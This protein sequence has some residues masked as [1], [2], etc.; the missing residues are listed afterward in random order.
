MTSIF[1]IGDPPPGWPEIPPRRL[2]PPLVIDA[3]PDIRAWAHAEAERIYAEVMVREAVPPAP[4]VLAE[5]RAQAQIW[6]RAQLVKI[7]STRGMVPTSELFPEDRPRPSPFPRK[8]QPEP[9][10]VA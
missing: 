10:E 1:E 6:A 3:A 9:E 2:L 4:E 8:V 5:E 7:A